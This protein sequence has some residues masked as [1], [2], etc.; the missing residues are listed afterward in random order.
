MEVRQLI[1][2]ASPTQCRIE[3]SEEWGHLII[4]LPIYLYF[5]FWLKTPNDEL[6]QEPGC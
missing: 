6:N 5:M 1:L 2:D 3:R 4:T